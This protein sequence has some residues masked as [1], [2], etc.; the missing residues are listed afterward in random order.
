MKLKNNKL[1]NKNNLKNNLKN[2]QLSKKKMILK[3]KINLKKEK[4]CLI[5][6]MV[7]KLINI[8]GHKHLKKLLLLYL[9]IK[10]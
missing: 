4:L 2:N 3:K 10:L 9:L 6:E 1:N 7:L 8:I 5:K